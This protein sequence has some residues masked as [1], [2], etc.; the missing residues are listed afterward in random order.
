MLGSIACTLA[1][2]S[3]PTTAGARRLSRNSTNRS[4]LRLWARTGVNF[5]QKERSIVEYLVDGFGKVRYS[6]AEP[7]KGVRNSFTGDWF[8]S[9][10]GWG[11]PARRSGRD[12]QRPDTG[13]KIDSWV[14]RSTQNSK[15]ANAP[16]G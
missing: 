9:R 13:A 16:S 2:V 11:K 5:R 15:G 10:A 12:G 1:L 14:R 6:P 8:E 7:C 4:A 3:T